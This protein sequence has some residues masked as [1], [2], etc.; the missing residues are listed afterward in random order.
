MSEVII[1][2]AEPLLKLAQTNE[3]CQKV[4]KL[5]VVAW[6]LALLPK[7]EQ[8]KF[9]KTEVPTISP[10][11]ARELVE[12]LE[13]LL[14]RKQIYFADDKRLIVDYLILESERGFDLVLASTPIKTEVMQGNQK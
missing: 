3:E 1:E 5:A 8:E 10:S 14:A 11:D 6:N 7:E 13:G 9:L 2:F 4:I 12:L